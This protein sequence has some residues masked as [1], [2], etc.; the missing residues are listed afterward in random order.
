MRGPEN[1][2]RPCSGDN[3]G[4]VLCSRVK[5][6]CYYK[7]YLQITIETVWKRKRKTSNCGWV[8]VVEVVPQLRSWVEFSLKITVPAGENVG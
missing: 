5:H 4:E 2:K 7:G 3:I 6:T 1:T 8:Q